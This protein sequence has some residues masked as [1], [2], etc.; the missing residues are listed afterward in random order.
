MPVVDSHVHAS[1]IWW[2]PIETHL[3]LMDRNH[4]DQAVLIQFWG[5]Q[6]NAYHFDAQRRYP[7]RFSNVVFVDSSRPDAVDQL[8][9]LAEQG[10]SGVRLRPNARSPGD[11][12]LAIWRAA[13]ELDLTIDCGGSFFK[14]EH[15]SSFEQLVK[16]LPNA[17]IVIEHIGGPNRPDKT[18]A[19]RR[20]RLKAVGLGRYTNLYMKIHGLGEF[21]ER[22]MPPSFAASPPAGRVRRRNGRASGGLA[23]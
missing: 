13:V 21:A 1:S 23:S 17:R 16:A 14:D 4:V 6:D 7:G 11:D 8:R 15:D 10:A 19:E 20:V 12:P 2:E 5:Q 9:R 18:D 22:A 3:F